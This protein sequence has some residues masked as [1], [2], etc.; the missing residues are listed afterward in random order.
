[1]T[2]ASAQAQQADSSQPA[3]SSH[4]PAKKTPQPY[5]GG[6]PLDVILHN[7]FWVTPPP[8]APFVKAAR[9]PEAT[10]E[11]TPTSEKE[12]KRPALRDAA[13][14]QQLQD[15]LEDGGAHNET[16]TKAKVRHFQAV[17]KKVVAKKVATK[18]LKKKTLASSPMRITPTSVADPR[19]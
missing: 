6:T 3:A 14:L 2:L 13:Q 5:G 18:K 1:M 7:K 9:P 15:E 11:Y 8:M 16:V 4:P 12:A 19:S 10:L 17:P